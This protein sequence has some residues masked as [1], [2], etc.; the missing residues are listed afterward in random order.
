[1]T[2]QGLKTIARKL[3]PGWLFVPRSPFFVSCRRGPVQSDEPCWNQRRLLRR[4]AGSSRRMTTSAFQ[5][6]SRAS[7]AIAKTSFSDRPWLTR[8][9]SRGAVTVNRPAPDSSIV[10]L[11]FPSLSTYLFG[12]PITDRRAWARFRHWPRAG[13]CPAVRIPASTGVHGGASASVS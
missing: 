7:L 1:M 9:G 2:Q 4:D 8:P 6:W 12:I 5:S 13:S 11:S 3:A 10:S